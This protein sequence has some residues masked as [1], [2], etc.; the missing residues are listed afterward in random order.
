MPIDASEYLPKGQKKR[1]GTTTLTHIPIEF[2]DQIGKDQSTAGISYP[3]TSI[4]S[5]LSKTFGSGLGQSLK[6][7]LPGLFAST[8]INPY[9]TANDDTLSTI[10]HEESHQLLNGLIDNGK[11][12]YNNIV[13]FPDIARTIA[14]RG[15]PS[16]EAPS[17][18][19]ERGGPTPS[20]VKDPFSKE[21]AQQLQK[22]DPQKAALWQ[23]LLTN[24]S[25]SG[26][27]FQ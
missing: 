4:G 18:A 21:F 26:V 8:Q 13:S 23:Q 15:S 1:K 19:V 5:T 14:G 27:N 16:L 10:H 7:L 22:V 6:Q 11:I 3:D 9:S 24:Y 20:N 12:D 2:V 25:G 17:Y